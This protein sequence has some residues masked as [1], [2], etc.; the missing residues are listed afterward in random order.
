MKETLFQIF[1]GEPVDF[2]NLVKFSQMISEK[3]TE[4]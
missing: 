2:E 1:G 3:Y 4:L